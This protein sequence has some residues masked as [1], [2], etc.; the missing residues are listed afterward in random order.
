LLQQV[1]PP[2][3]S[4]AKNFIRQPKRT[5]QRYPPRAAVR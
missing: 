2:C 1:F 4:E 5:F 3:T